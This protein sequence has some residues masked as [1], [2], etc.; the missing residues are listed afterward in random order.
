MS[1]FLALMFGVILGYALGIVAVHIW[2]GRQTDKANDVVGYI[3][4]DVVIKKI[5]EW[6]GPCRCSK[7]YTSRNRRDPQCRRC[8]FDLE[9]FV[10]DLDNK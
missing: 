8:D 10:E 5:I 1:E 9:Q 3:R 7:E 4:K 6:I 2:I